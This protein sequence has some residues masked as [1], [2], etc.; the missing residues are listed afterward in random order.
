MDTGCAHMFQNKQINELAAMYSVFSRLPDT[1]QFIV[2][3]MKAYIEKTGSEIVMD[4]ENLKDPLKF[5]RL[6]LSFKSEMDQVVETCFDKNMDFE[7]AR[8]ESFQQF[9]NL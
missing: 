2:A 6:L 8:D 4:E 5:V 1:L 3:K 9:M 7:K